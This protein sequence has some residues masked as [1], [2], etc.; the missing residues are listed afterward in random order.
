V[1][2][3]GYG[4]AKASKTT[5]NAWDSVM[6]D[7]FVDNAK[8]KVVMLLLDSRISPTE[9]D[10]QMLDYLA[11]NE[12]PAILVLTKTDKITRSELNNAINKISQ[13]LRY[14]KELIIPTSANKK[15]GV[16]NLTKILENF[17]KF[18]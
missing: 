17:V 7:Y 11:E 4:F 9:L 14:N 6:N 18:D 15:L 10:K 16:E 3:P 13:E 5:T 8:L 1:D 12:I 2:L